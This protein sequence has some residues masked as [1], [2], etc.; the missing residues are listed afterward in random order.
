MGHAEHRAESEGD[1]TV[2]PQYDYG[3]QWFDDM[4]ALAISFRDT[5]VLGI[6]LARAGVAT[7]DDMNKIAKAIM[8]SGIDPYA[9]EGPPM[10]LGV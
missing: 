2:R 7:R 4:G 3:G 1:A 8:D 9:D 10:D 6:E 5:P